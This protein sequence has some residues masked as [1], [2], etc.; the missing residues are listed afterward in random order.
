MVLLDIPNIIP[1]FLGIG[2]CAG[3]V[4]AFSLLNACTIR[5]PPMAIWTHKVGELCGEVDSLT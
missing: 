3:T 1:F 5:H 4:A 2:I